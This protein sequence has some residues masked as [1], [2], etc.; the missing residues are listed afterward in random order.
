MS[1]ALPLQDAEVLQT[2]RTMCSH[3]H[4]AEKL[5]SKGK[6]GSKLPLLIQTRLL[7]LHITNKLPC[8]NLEPSK[9]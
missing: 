7:E 2:P 5:F 6:S 8:I 1:L 9:K 4:L 3:C